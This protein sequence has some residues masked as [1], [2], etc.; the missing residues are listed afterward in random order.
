[1]TA[2]VT[3]R[4]DHGRTFEVPADRLNPWH[5]INVRADSWWMAHPITCDLAA[6]D[7]DERARN[8]PSSPAA[9]GTYRWLDVNG[10]IESEPI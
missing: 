5:T 1:M 3:L 7:F 10:P 4:D 6:C 8:W 2:R 9:V